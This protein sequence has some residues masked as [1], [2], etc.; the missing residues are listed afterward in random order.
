MPLEDS[1]KPHFHGHRQRLRERFMAGGGDALPDYE[2]LELVLAQA[3]PRG[4]VKPLAKLLL[5]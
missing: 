2:L 1:A 5:G 4:G 3:I